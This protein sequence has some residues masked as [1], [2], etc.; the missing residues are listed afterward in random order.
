MVSLQTSHGCHIALVQL[1]RLERAGVGEQ[2]PEQAPGQLGR[3]VQGGRGLAPEEVNRGEEVVRAAPTLKQL[4]CCIKS[5][6][7][8]QQCQFR[9]KPF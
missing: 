8:G 7:N 3:V 2:L 6:I 5:C 4:I 9:Q 1:E